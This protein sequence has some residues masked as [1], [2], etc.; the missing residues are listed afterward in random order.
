[1]ATFTETSVSVRVE[2]S[3]G[4][5]EDGQ[6]VVESVLVS[7]VSKTADGEA[8]RKA[9]NVDATASM[10]AQQR[11]ATTLLLDAAEAW[12]KSRWGIT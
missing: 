6:T 11:A 7:A 4:F 2:L 12:A 9:T 3:R 8:V 1:M 10:N 5:A